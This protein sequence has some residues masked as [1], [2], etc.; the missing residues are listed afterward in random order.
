MYDKEKNF[1]V[2]HQFEFVQLSERHLGQVI[3]MLQRISPFSPKLETVN[4]HLV[5]YLSQAHVSSTVLQDSDGRAV[6]F[7]AVVYEQKLRGGILGHIEDIVISEDRSGIGLGRA[8]ISHLVEEAFKA[9]CYKV[10]LSCSPEV[11]QFYEKCGFYQAGLSMR[12]LAADRFRMEQD[13]QRY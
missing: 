2:E 3:S 9:G 5:D 1:A 11:S 10:V 4:K 7:G 6:G 12:I 13:L 8:L